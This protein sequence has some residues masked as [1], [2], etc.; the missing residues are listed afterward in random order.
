[1]SND[2]ETSGNGAAQDE[3]WLARPDMLKRLE[4]GLVAACI[5]G[6]AAELLVTKHG[7]FAIANLFG[8]YAIC[9][10]ASCMVLALVAKPLGRLLMRSEDYYDR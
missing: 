8:F 3:G 2:P 5:L 9:G 6:L 7:K 10:F 4:Y 1:V